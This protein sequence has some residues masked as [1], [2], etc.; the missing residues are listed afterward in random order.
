MKHNK[1]RI[2]FTVLLL[3]FPFFQGGSLVSAKKGT[4]RFSP[5]SRRARK[6]KEIRRKIVHKQHLINT[7]ISSDTHSALDLETIEDLIK[8]K[9]Y[10]NANNM[11]A[12]F[13]SGHPIN[14]RG[15]YLKALVSFLTGRLD[16]AIIYLNQSLIYN[17]NSVEAHKLMGDIYRKS[18]E[19]IGAITYYTNALGIDSGNVSSLINRGICYYRINE[20][21]KALTD[22]KRSL[23]YKPDNPVLKKLID[24]ITQEKD[25][26]E[27]LTD[28]IEVDEH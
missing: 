12:E 19:Y 11:L 8:K 15:Y 1:Y 10:D 7:S 21:D 6:H 2:I 17:Y 3:I 5:F 22:W 13:L 16:K 4:D 9:K 24:T 26:A 20:V 28:S 23:R 18:N 27:S 14:A 25:R